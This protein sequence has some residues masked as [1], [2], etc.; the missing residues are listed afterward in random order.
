MEYG[1]KPQFGRKLNFEE[2]HWEGD[3]GGGK[4][5]SKVNTF[6]K[7]LESCDQ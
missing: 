4:H 2:K 5:E 1:P 6:I 3:M 7:L